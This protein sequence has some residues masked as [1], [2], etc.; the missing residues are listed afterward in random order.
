[1]YFINLHLGAIGSVY[2]QLVSALGI[3]QDQTVVA[4]QVQNY[5]QELQQI[6]RS[7][8]IIT[9]NGIFV[10][11]NFQLNDRFQDVATQKFAADVHQTDYNSATFAINLINS[12]VGSQTHNMID[13]VVVQN[14]G[15]ISA[16]TRVVSV[17][18]IYFGGSF[19]HR[20]NKNDSFEGPFN[21]GDQIGFMTTTD[22]YNYAL[23][24]DLSASAIEMEYVNSNLTLVVVLPTTNNLNELVANLQNYDWN[25]ITEQMQ[26]RTVTVTLPKFG[27]NARVSLNSYLNDVRIAFAFSFTVVAGVNGND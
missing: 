18:G 24:P 25:K 22:T 6:A 26:P 4:D 11:N 13:N 21:G 8:E 17:N 5:N 12:Y 7:A 16:N 1:M 14:A 9:S 20:F 19:N 3:S 2:D 23:L 27:A 15:M 10:Q